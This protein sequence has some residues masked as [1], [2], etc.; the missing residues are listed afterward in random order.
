MVSIM[1]AAIMYEIPDFAGYYV[2]ETGEIFTTLRKGCI[3]R[4]DYSKRIDPI[5]LKPRYTKGGYP[6]VYI[7][8]NSTNLREDVYIYRAVAEMFIPNP[9]NLPEV[10]HI[11]SNTYDSRAANLEWVTHK[12][13]MDY[14]ITDG[15]M[16]RDKYGRYCHK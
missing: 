11:N 15:N 5:P 13:N 8:R 4:Y 7:R 14:A 6:R 2:A 9:N 12:E 1:K 10:N 16:A 3:D